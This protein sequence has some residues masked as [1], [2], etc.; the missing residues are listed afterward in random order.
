MIDENLL[1]FIWSHRLL[2][3]ITITAD[4]NPVE[5]INPGLLNTNQGPDFLNAKIVIDKTLWVGNVEI[6]VKS[7]DWYLH[8]HQIDVNFS[9]VICHVVWKNDAQ[10][11]Y[12]DGRRIPTIELSKQ[13]PHYLIDNFESLMKSQ[14]RIPCIKLI[15]DVPLHI[16]YNMLE[17]CYIESLKVKLSKI[18]ETTNERHGNFD[19]VAYNVIVRNFGFKI[20]NDAFE[21][22]A[23]SL[24][25]NILRRYVNNSLAIEALTFG[26]AG[27]LSESYKDNYP[28]LLM[29]EY[30]YYAAKHH[31]R[32][33]ISAKWNLLRLHA[34]NF[35]CIRIAQ[36]CAFINNAFDG[37]DTILS[38]R[39]IHDVCA[40]FEGEV[41]K[42]W[43][44][45]S[46]FDRTCSSRNSNIGKSSIY[47]IAINSFV[48]LM[49]YYG[50]KFSL[51]QITSTAL[52]MME[53]IPAE[54][55][56]I[57]RLWKSLDIKALN[58][59]H[60]QALI[61]LKQYYCDRHRCLACKIGSKII[62]S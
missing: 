59:L 23:K 10:V 56:N 46:M 50:Q 15:R 5:I 42:Y 36:L 1:S 52:N 2:P 54:N 57:I 3:Q 29:K 60:S 4:D 40:L 34:S 35:P 28:K 27:I 6:H 31:L 22:T 53:N 25:Y 48:P 44:T 58:A 49:Y 12:T 47:L 41:N 26:Q 51:P 8:F 39:N 43:N 61:F 37:L 16:V 32:P 38:L 13:I 20:N 24:P 19:E 33:Q 18:D 45:H 62:R 55:N 30:S 9:N 14:N 21:A 11:F 17:C 7:S